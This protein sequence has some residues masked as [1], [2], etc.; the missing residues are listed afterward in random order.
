MRSA[1]FFAGLY[2]AILFLVALTKDQFGNQGLILV[3]AVSGLTDVDA[4]TLST[5]QLVRLERLPTS[6]GWRMV[7]MAIL[8]NLVFKLATVL[9]L[10]DRVLKIRVGVVFLAT[11]GVGALLLL[12]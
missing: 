8:S 12:W 5:A 11:I 3:A 6:E 1:L 7:V 9:F 4:I 2:A 10:A